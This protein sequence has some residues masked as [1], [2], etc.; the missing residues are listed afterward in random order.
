[1]RHGIQQPRDQRELYDAP[2]HDNAGEHEQ[3]GEAQ[4][5]GAEVAQQ[6]LVVGAGVLDPLASERELRIEGVRRNQDPHRDREVRH[7]KRDQQ[8]ADF[9]PARLDLTVVP[10]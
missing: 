2:V 5:A 7:P 9:P 6:V 10:S 1:M 8:P 4:E 3:R